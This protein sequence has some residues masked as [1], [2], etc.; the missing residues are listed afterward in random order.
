M[1]LLQRA[2]AY[3]VVG[4]LSLLLGCSNGSGNLEEPGQQTAPP[5]SQPS[6]FSVGG[7]VSGLAGSGL[8]LQLNGAGT[9][10]IGGD[11]AFVF[12]GLLTEGSAYAVT[13]A[14]QPTAPDQACSV[15]NGA[16]T[17]SGSNVASVV[18]SCA[19]VSAG[20]F[21]VG[22]TV[23]GVLGSGLALRLNGTE[24]LPIASNGASQSF[25]N[26]RVRHRIARS[27][28]A[29]EPSRAKSRTSR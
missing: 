2:S 14:A 26:P 24:E 6:G 1:S 5:P 18:V 4:G 3:C 9:L 23:S 25:A 27:I 16:G 13:V 15:A 8:V 7:M 21:G 22:G 19:G 10:P 12:G 20:T 11:G 28:A 17:V 29:T